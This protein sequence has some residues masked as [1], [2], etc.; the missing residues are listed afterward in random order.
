LTGERRTR[1]I[2]NH[3][4]VKARRIAGRPG[5]RKG[6]RTKPGGPSELGHGKKKVRPA[7]FPQ[8]GQTG[9][10]HWALDCST[11]R[12]EEGPNQC[13]KRGGGHEEG[14]KKSI[15]GPGDCIIKL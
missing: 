9:T 12:P 6:Q 7:H 3:W 1:E 2:R 5:G 11:G 4:P 15:K 10:P 13:H 14:P 8:R